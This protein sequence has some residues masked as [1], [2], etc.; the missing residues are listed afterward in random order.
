MLYTLPWEELINGKP[1]LP[2]VIELP[3]SQQ[4]LASTVVVVFPELHAA[5][6]QWRALEPAVEHVAV[7]DHRE[8]VGAGDRRVVSDFPAV[9]TEV[10]VLPEPQA[11]SP[12][13][14]RL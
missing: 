3:L 7:A 10:R 13:S 14:A 2:I 11:G 6:P 5:F 1:S 9:S 12:R 4:L 8:R